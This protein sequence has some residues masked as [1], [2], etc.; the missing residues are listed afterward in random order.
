MQVEE[1]LGVLALL[2]DKIIYYELYIYGTTVAPSLSLDGLA[3]EGSCMS[4]YSK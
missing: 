4:I 3:L 1:S 2:K